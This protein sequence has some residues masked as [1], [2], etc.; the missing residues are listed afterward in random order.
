MS[1]LISL[2]KNIGLSEKEAVTYLI[3]LKV[4]TNP[5][6]VIAKNAEINRC[7]TYFILESLLKK[8]L[9]T[10][11]EKDGIKFFTSVP[12]Q[13]LINYIDE[14]R[15]DLAYYKNEIL[16]LLPNFKSLQH[17]DQIMPDIKSY[18]GSSGMSQIYHS[19]SQE[20]TLMLWCSPSNK[21]H[22]FFY[23]YAPDFL[24]RNKK[25]KLIIKYNKKILRKKI[26][27]NYELNMLPDLKPIEF[28]SDIKAYI[29]SGKENFGIEIV[30][31]GIV[32]FLK[33]KFYIIWNK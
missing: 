8:G 2:L 30:N 12:P 20:K 10:Q 22:E 11:F 7:T 19:A 16:S 15:H 13:N 3:N 25:I 23:R 28:I 17:K 24:K 29:I 4:G 18:S 32:K 14:K 1:T 21:P 33:N 9:V 26:K 5:A 31:Q 27:D 6:S